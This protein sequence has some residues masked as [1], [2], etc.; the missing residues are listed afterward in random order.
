MGFLHTEFSS[1]ELPH[2]N[3]KSSNILLAPNYEP[4]L[5]D[6]AMY[7]LI[8]DNQSIQALT[9]S[10]SPEYVLY[11][12]LSPKSDVFCLGVV[13]LEIMTRKSP[14]QYVSGG[15]DVV[16]WVRQAIAE[17]KLVELLDPE[18][19]TSSKDSID[20]MEKMLR[21]GAACTESDHE[22]R[23]EMRESIRSIEE[24]QNYS[25]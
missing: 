19:T 3:L 1:H 10:K 23:I 13:I 11:Q 2:G 21:I 17:D 25:V 6:Y 15:T 24:I 12:V 5:T 7:P 9:A 4:L 20:Q 16:Q 8:N 14:A 22:R 18:L